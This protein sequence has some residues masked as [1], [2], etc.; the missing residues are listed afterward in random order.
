M[1]AFKYWIP[2][3]L[4]LL[5]FTSSCGSEPPITPPRTIGD[6]FK[7]KIL[8]GGMWGYATNESG[9]WSRTMNP[10]TGEANC[11][12][13]YTETQVYGTINQG[14]LGYFD[15]VFDHALFVCTKVAAAGDIPL[16]EFGGMW[17]MGS[18]NSTTIW[19]PN[20][21][22]NLP[23]NLTEYNSKMGCPTGFQD[24]TVLSTPAIDWPL[25][26]CWKPNFLSLNAYKSFGGIYGLG[27]VKGA[28]YVY[29]NPV[30]MGSNCPAPMKSIQTYGTLN[31][32]WAIYQ[33]AD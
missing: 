11:P 17:G 20:P 26:L 33:C 30:T 24:A 19:F 22:T 29:K 31:L 16:L 6:D 7:N 21:K 4:S 2:L 23:T 9:V 14:A 32:D 5:S 15:H 10:A 13:G 28:T 1:N 8:F 27:L 25:H 3:G 18:V 12:P